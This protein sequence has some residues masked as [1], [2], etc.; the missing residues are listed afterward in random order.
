MNAIRLIAISAMLTAF[1]GCMNI[2]ASLQP[3]DK[4]VKEER[5]ASDC[6]PIIFGFSYGTA[7]VEEALTEEVHLIGQEFQGN[8]KTTPRRV[9][10][11]PPQRIAKVRRV[12][13]HDYNFFG[14]GARCV[15]VFG[16]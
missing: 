6:I 8:R 15:E 1:S 16:E 7:T 10:Y 3:E 5:R 11:V 4:A 13:L 12:Q 9:A 14:F 2:A